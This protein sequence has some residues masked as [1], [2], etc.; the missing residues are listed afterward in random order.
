MLA[1]SEE[2]LSKAYEQK[3]LTGEV[4]QTYELNVPGHKWFSGR[5]IEMAAGSPR[6]RGR[7]ETGDAI[8]QTMVPRKPFPM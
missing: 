5:S 6:D 7:S 8:V 1:N 3:S 4:R 2:E